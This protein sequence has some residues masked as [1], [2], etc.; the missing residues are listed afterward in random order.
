MDDFADQL[1]NKTQAIILA[2]SYKRRFSPVC[3]ERPKALLPLLNIPL[4]DYSIEFLANGGVK[5]IY[6]VATAFVKQIKDHLAR[7]P[8][9]KSIQKL[10]EVTCTLVGEE[11][12][13]CVG[14]A[15]R[16]IRDLG[17]INC[18]PFVLVGADV[19]ANFSLEDY[20]EEHKERYRK[21][22]ED[23]HLDTKLLTIFFKRASPDHRSRAMEHDLFVCTSDEDHE[24]SGK[25]LRYSVG[26]MAEECV[27]PWSVLKRSQ[28]S[29][30][31][32][33]DLIECGLSLCS[34]EILDEFKDGCDLSDLKTNLGLSDVEGYASILEQNYAAEI[35]D[36][37]T[38][39]GISLDLIQR[40]AFP[41]VPENNLLSQT[42]YTFRRK[43]IYLENDVHLGKGSQ[44]LRDTVIGKQSRVGNKTTI[45][46]CVI[47]RYVKIGSN[48]RLSHCHIFDHAWIGNN[49]NMSYAVVAD[50]ATIQ[51]DAEIESG[52]VFSYGTT[53]DHSLHLRSHTYLTCFNPEL[54]EAD[55]ET[56]TWVSP[57][58][59]PTD[60]D[61]WIYDPRVCCIK[62]TPLED[63]LVSKKHELSSSQEL[64][65]DPMLDDIPQQI[66][67]CEQGGQPLTNVVM[68]LNTIAQTSASV[69]EFCTA[70]FLCFFEIVIGDL[71]SDLSQSMID[72]MKELLQKY[73]MLLKPH[74]EDLHNQTHILAA[75]TEACLKEPIYRQLCV[76][77]ICEL[78]E[79][80]IVDEQLIFERWFA[81][82]QKRAADDPRLED[83][84]TSCEVFIEWIRN[85]STDSE[86]SEESEEESQPGAFGAL[87]EG[88]GGPSMI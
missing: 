73:H 82:L 71:T 80:D 40:W 16:Y 62:P 85:S 34:P 74:S 70:L 15:L 84:H 51:E 13:T 22:L 72:R 31:V 7:S 23:N 64:D 8:V 52:C 33:F 19:I 81:E 42:S 5:Q 58:F 38:Y 45:D 56:R 86:G 76:H 61:S 79:L 6:I 46:H 49:V 21:L 29:F 43:N 77:M 11:S 67:L 36:W 28:T 39:H 78:Y 18:N 14:D 54:N 41:L 87:R 68:K 4:L 27:L 66:Q 60:P 30:D 12:F 44:I 53:V 9:V 47:G 65:K 24:S 59:D 83:L 25:I 10:E 48:C 75:L 88:P 2:D 69:Q 63:V 50:R 35:V 17:Y 20:I 55:E 1:D 37:P 3:L 32:H 26:R 57:D